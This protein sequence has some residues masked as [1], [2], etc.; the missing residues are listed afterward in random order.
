M[1]REP[2]NTRAPFNNVVR[3]P[4][5]SQNTLGR[6]GLAFTL[7]I[8]GLIVGANVSGSL[9]NRLAKRKPFGIR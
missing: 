9:F 5:L 7:K 8:G 4:P 1:L 6:M 2:V 3:R